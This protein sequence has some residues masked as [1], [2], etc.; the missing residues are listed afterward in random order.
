[1]TL[2]AAP[3]GSGGLVDPST[4]GPRRVVVPQRLDQSVL[5]D[6]RK[7]E[8][9]GPRVSI[10]WSCLRQEAEPHAHLA[11]ASHTYDQTLNQALPTCCPPILPSPC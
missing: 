5:E 11:G 9:F 6:V 4:G 10:C 3:G 2:A 8:A 7:A 1:M